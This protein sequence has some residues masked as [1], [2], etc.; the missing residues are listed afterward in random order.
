MAIELLQYIAYF[1]DFLATAIPY[2][3]SFWV[4]EPEELEDE[5]PRDE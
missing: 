3:Q 2:I 5:L 1:L 4:R